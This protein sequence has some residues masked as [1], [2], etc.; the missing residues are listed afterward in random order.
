MKPTQKTLKKLITEE[1]QASRMYR[2]YNL[3]G[4]AKQETKHSKILGKL[5]KK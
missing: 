5:L 2:K 4:I 1:K 3:P